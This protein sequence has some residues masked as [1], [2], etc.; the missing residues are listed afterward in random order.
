MTARHL[1]ESFAEKIRR[2]V[3]VLPGGWPT[4]DPTDTP[5]T[6]ALSRRLDSAFAD[7]RRRWKKGPEAAL[8]PLFTLHEELTLHPGFP[9]ITPL[10]YYAAALFK[11]TGPDLEEPGFGRWKR[12]ID[13][14]LL[15]FCERVVSSD[16]VLSQIYQVSIRMICDL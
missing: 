14:G 11:A 10:A 1:Q 7:A 5:D 16:E 13:V 12:L 8:E 6:A 9:N 3:V 15:D 2:D 4:T